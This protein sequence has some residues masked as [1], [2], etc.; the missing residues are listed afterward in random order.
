MSLQP[1]YIGKHSGDMIV[2]FGFTGYCIHDFKTERIINLSSCS[3][4]PSVR[5]PIHTYRSHTY[6]QLY[7][8]PEAITFPLMPFS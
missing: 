3:V 6:T 1:S 8:M 7:V 5:A 4:A 2:D